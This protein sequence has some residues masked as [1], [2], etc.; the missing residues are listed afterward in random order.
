MKVLVTIATACALSATL[1]A[2]IPDFTPQTPLI[3][4]LLHNDVADAADETTEAM[5]HTIGAWQAE[6]DAFYSLPA[7]RPPIESSAFAATALSLRALQLYGSHQFPDGSWL[8]RTRTFPV[9]PYRESGFPH[10]KHQWISASG[11]SWAAMA[12]ALALPQPSSQS[13]Q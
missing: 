11:T 5:A 10:G 3:G 4:A 7:L 8:V 6:D 2:Q 1:G 12:L 9:Q 13:G